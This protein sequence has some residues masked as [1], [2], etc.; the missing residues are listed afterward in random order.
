MPPNWL[1]WQT[2]GG[3]EHEGLVVDVDSNVLI[4][5]CTDGVRRAVEG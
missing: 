3:D 2:L 4:V 1:R 5:E